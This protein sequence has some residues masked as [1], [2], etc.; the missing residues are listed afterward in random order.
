MENY[1]YKLGTKIDTK[2]RIGMKDK[3]FERFKK[4]PNTIINVIEKPLHDKRNF[5]CSCELGELKVI[6]C[7]RDNFQ[8][9]FIYDIIND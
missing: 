9:Y 7:Y 1:K 2:I 3:F 4:I 6:I 8:E 5:L